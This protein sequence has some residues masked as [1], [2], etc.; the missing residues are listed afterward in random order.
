MVLYYEETPIYW[1]NHSLFHFAEAVG[2]ETIDEALGTISAAFVALS[3]KKGSPKMTPQAGVVLARMFDS[4]IETGYFM[5]NEK[6]PVNRGLPF[7]LAVNP[8]AIEILM[9]LF[10]ESTSAKPQKTAEK[11]S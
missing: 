10:V 6:R 1:N 11:K 2:V 9:Q 5:L 8:Q 4:A 7:D 3:N